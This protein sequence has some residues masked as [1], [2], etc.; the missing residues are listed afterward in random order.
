VIIPGG[1]APDFM[2]RTPMMAKFV[3]DIHDQGKVVA[4]I[5]HG[6]W[7]LVSAGLLKG[8]KVTCFFA[9]K[10]DLIAAGADYVDEE[11]VVDKNLITSRKPE[12]LTAFVVEIIKQLT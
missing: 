8:R 5:C 6:G 2:R 10:D 4:A 3:K 7:M 11:V 1:F 9:I 12:D